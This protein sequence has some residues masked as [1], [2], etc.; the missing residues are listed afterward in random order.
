MTA[1]ISAVRAEAFRVPLARPVQFATRAVA[2]RE[3]VVVWIEAEGVTGTG[4]T[5]AGTAGGRLVRDA[6]RDLLAPS[7]E[8]A[9]AG[10]I[11]GVWRALYQETLLL[12]RRGAVIRALSAV[13]TAL[14]DREAVA[15]GL[16]LYRC[17]GGTE[18][19][20][21]AYASGGY[22]GGGAPF[23]D[24]DDPLRLVALEMER[25]VER[26]FD[27]V[28]MKIGRDHEL[29]VQRVRV[30]RETL[31]PGRRLALD[32]NN[33]WTDP[34]D[35]IAFVRAVER[36]EPWWIEEPLPPDDPL[37][38]AE[39]ARALDTPVA[40]GEINQT[41]WE[42]EALIRAG[43]ADILQP[44]VAVIGGVSEWLAVARLA[45]EASLP[46]APHWY[47]PLHVHLAAATPHCLTVE[48]FSLDLDIYNF[49]AL[50]RED[51][52]LVPKDG[53]LVA[54]ERPGH[55]VELDPAALARFRV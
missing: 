3:Y 32:A 16:P 1:R 31:G 10:D 6:V 41:R 25:N 17:L 28:K 43:G 11:E 20:V 51:A 53:R 27:A 4:H 39:V 38:H 18:P 12:G 14:H 15:A 8:G 19:S 24:E 36:Y 5:Y 35:A 23:G 2:A 21:H 52:R 34:A 50:I 29:D 55:G 44:D 9:D 30:A 37:G 33:A 13:D 48:H 7:L 47:H 40:T 42:F 45:A 54:P 22:Y 46:V 26:G 49:D